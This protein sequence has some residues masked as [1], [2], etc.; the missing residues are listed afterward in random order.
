MEIGPVF[1]GG[2]L[3][4]PV[5]LLDHVVATRTVGERGQ[6]KRGI[7]SA[8]KEERFALRRAVSIS[9]IPKGSSA[10][11][12]GASEGKSVPPLSSYFWGESP[13]QIFFLLS[14]FI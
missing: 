6:M 5:G 10:F 1:V 14:Q 11:F 4:K 13:I 7:P 3:K 9:K 2:G 12:K 8:G